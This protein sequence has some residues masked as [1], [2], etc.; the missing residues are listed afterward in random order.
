MKKPLLILLATVCMS[1]AFGQQKPDTAKKV[2]INQAEVWDIHS[3]L[4]RALDIIHRVHFDAVQRD[5]IDR[6]LAPWISE[7]ERRYQNAI[8]EKTEGVKK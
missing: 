4:S 6:Y 1:A 7:I 3:R 8:P 5:S 2:K